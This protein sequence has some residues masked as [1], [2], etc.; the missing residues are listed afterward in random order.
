MTI[1]AA[2][3]TLY[4]VALLI[5]IGLLSIRTYKLTRMTF[6]VIV[7]A[8]LAVVYGLILGNEPL[9]FSVPFVFVGIYRVGN[10]VRF[11][12]GRMHEDYLYA[13]TARSSLILGIWQATIGISA[14]IVKQATSLSIILVCLA[15]AAI[16]SLVVGLFS[17]IQALKRSR[18]PLPDSYLPDTE[19]PSVTVAIPARNETDD[20]AACLQSFLASDYKK[21]EIIVYDDCSYDKTSEVIKKFAHDGVR[22]VNGSEPGDTWL[23]KNAAYNK[24]SQEATGDIL[25]FCGVDVRVQIDTVRLLIAELQKQQLDMASVLPLRAS[26]ASWLSYGQI[27]RYM[28]ELCIPRYL[29]KRPPVLSTMWI[30]RAKA[31]KE[32]G[33]LAAVKRAIVPEAH[34]AHALAKMRRYAFWRSSKEM[35][36]DSYKTLKQQQATSIRVRYPQLHKRPENVLALTVAELIIIT[37]PLFSYFVLPFNWWI[38]FASL[39]ALLVVLI[40]II[41]SSAITKTASVWYVLQTIIALPLDIVLTHMSLWKYEFSRVYWKQRDV[42]MPVMHVIP[43]LPKL[44][45]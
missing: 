26:V 40:A 21:L 15:I 39:F 9:V 5:E 7:T 34:F 37:A 4:V 22:F 6:S 29:L 28:W 23:A 11:A 33:G 14:V 16:A 35:H 13:V 1:A 17:L 10:I 12:A 32:L 25:I 20:L 42:C 18:L 36:V 3:W 27:I 31:L 19:L 8:L 45:D 30:I 2:I 38:V 41:M 43:S 44:E 24:L